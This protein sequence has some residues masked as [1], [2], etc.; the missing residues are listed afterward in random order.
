MCD[1]DLHVRLEAIQE[2]GDQLLRHSISN[3]V[4]LDTTTP[5]LRKRRSP[6]YQDDQQRT[7][8]E[9]M[10]P[11][12][13]TN[14]QSPSSSSTT[15]T[16]RYHRNNTQQQQHHVLLPLTPPLHEEQPNAKRQRRQ[17]RDHNNPPA[18]IASLVTENRS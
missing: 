8:R 17:M 10:T 5:S 13:V 18:N 6:S 1:F 12:S 3:L 14:A 11:C 9:K 16:T 7:C 4:P 15:S 2:Y